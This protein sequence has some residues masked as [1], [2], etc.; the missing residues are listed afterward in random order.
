MT[1]RRRDRITALAPG[2]KAPIPRMNTMAMTVAQTPNASGFAKRRLPFAVSTRVFAYPPPDPPYSNPIPAVRHHPD[3][4]LEH[5]G[6]QKN[7]PK[8]L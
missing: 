6:Q 1:Y 4:D 7:F 8:T 2:F 5:L 3:A